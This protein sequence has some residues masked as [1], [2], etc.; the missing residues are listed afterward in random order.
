MFCRNMTVF[1]QYIN[2][3][4]WVKHYINLIIMDNKDNFM[5]VI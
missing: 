3:T 2:L 5:Y 4:Y 1:G